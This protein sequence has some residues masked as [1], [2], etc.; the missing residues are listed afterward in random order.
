MNIGFQPSSVPIFF[1]TTC[2]MIDFPVCKKT[3]TNMLFKLYIYNIL[4]K[5]IH[6]L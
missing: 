6:C 2:R 5:N 3:A 1:H 4:S